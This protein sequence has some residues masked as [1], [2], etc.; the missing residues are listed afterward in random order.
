MG[1]EDAVEELFKQ[2]PLQEGLVGAIDFSASH[3]KRKNI[4]I[5]GT[6]ETS[7]VVSAALELPCKMMASQPGTPQ[8]P[9]TP[10]EIWVE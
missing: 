7:Q 10:A 3:A 2:D 5:L 9:R 1:D 4:R 8:R 6:S